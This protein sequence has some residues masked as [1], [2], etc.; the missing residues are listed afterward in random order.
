MSRTYPY[1]FPDA[2]A[3][4]KV[5]LSDPA[6]AT[7]KGTRYASWELAEARNFVLAEGG[8]LVAEARSGLNETEGDEAVAAALPYMNAA[9]AL[10]Q[11]A[12]HLAVAVA[13]AKRQENA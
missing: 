8:R 3:I 7:V 5:V 2:P 11:Y 10:F 9:H 6:D 13:T 4:V 1:P 12:D